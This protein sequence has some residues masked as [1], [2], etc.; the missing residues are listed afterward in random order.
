MSYLDDNRFNH[1]VEND[2]N[3]HFAEDLHSYPQS[4]SAPDFSSYKKPLKKEKK[5]GKSLT[6]KTAAA[7][8]A[9]CITASATVGFGG[10]YL[11]GTLSENGG[12]RTQTTQ[13][14][15]MTASSDNS[16][17]ALLAQSASSGS[18]L[19]VAQI[20]ALTA[21]SVVEI[22]TESVTTGTWMNQYISEGAGS[23]VIISSDGYIVTNNHV[24]EGSNSI[25]VT[26]RNGNSYDATLVGTDS[27]ADV[28]V[29]KIDATGLQAAAMGDSDSLVVGETAVAIGNPL[30]ELGG[31]VTDGIISALDR[32]ISLDGE[33][34]NLL[35]TNAAINP[36]NSG[37]GL[38]NSQGQLVGIVVAK[39]S[40]ED[41]EGLGFAIPIND[42]KTVVDELMQYGYVRGRVALG[43]SVVDITS[44]TVARMYRVNY[45]GAYVASVTS[46]SSAETAGLEAGDYIASVNGT[47]VSS[48]EDLESIKSSLSV[49]DTVTME[50]YRSGQ[51]KTVSFNADEYVPS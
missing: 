34:M 28:A 38:F 4:Y 31:T 7:F 47:K 20:A 49:G 18:D 36:G 22:T 21:D 11:A 39:S 16:S 12:N 6:L 29:V 13:T 5:P 37:G 50:V 41:V 2:E 15:P 27:Q 42:V 48:S 40:G 32:E 14:T 46:G 1:N 35:Q 43:F 17:Y 51:T 30:G 8:A 19:T 9:I 25:K 10:G 44:A 33:T 24:I 3:K 26:L 23:G 45:L